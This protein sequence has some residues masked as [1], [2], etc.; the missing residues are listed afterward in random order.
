MGVG[1]GVP[2]TITSSIALAAELIKTIPQTAN[3]PGIYFFI[4]KISI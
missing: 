4:V 1:I 2:V 3:K